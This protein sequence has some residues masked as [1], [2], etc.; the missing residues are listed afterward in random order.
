MKEY[1]KLKEEA[2][3][4]LEELGVAYETGITGNGYYFLFLYREKPIYKLSI[5]RKEFNEE[6]YQHLHRLA[7]DFS[8]EISFGNYRPKKNL[9]EW[10]IEKPIGI[11]SDYYNYSLIIK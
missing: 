3:Q 10:C 4:I 7:Q 8:K 5:R 2:D 11:D 1:L 9:L 6:A